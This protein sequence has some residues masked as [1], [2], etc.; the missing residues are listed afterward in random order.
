MY[1]LQEFVKAKLTIKNQLKVI[2][3]IRRWLTVEQ[4]KLFRET[5]FGPWLDLRCP[6]NDP[7]YVHHL[8][9]LR[10]DP[11]VL[12]KTR[13]EDEELWFRIMPGYS[14]RFGRREFCLVTGFRFGPN[15]DMDRYIPSGVRL[16][17]PTFKQRVF[18]DLGI[19]IHLK[20]IEDK[21][22]DRSTFI[23]PSKLSDDDCVR[24]CIIYL[25][26]IG[27]M[28]KQASHV[29]EIDF[30]HLV[31]DFAA[32]NEYPWGSRIWCRTYEQLNQGLGTRLS[33]SGMRYTLS[34][35]VWAFKVASTLLLFF[36]LTYR[37]VYNSLKCKFDYC[38]LD[39]DMGGILPSFGDRCS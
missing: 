26:E 15:V 35:F 2:S 39:L 16:M 23:G 25:V 20:E 6:D 30:M 5:C 34:G 24:L 4:E 36:K 22:L 33:Q 7:G 18:R 14:I 10:C 28:G 17:P 8:L 3:L 1:F 13:L 32:V 31:G 21:V 27:F 38:L 19:T 29:V 9:Q 11:P 12:K 37:F